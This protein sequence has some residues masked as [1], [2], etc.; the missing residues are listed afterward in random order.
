MAGLLGAGLAGR[1]LSDAVLGAA[2]T[3][4]SEEGFV[5][6]FDGKSLN[7]W[8]TNARPI[9]HGTGGKWRVEDWTITGEQDP[10]GSGNGGV[11]LSDREYGDFELALELAPDWGVDSGV[12]LRTNADGV[13]FQVYVDYHD[14][15][16]VG[17][18]STETVSGQRRMIIRPFNFFGKL[19]EQRKIKSLHTKPDERDVAWKQDYLRFSAT[20]ETWLSTWKIGAWNTLRIRCVGNY[21]QITTWINETK[22]AEFDGS[23]CPQPDYN[24]AEM[25]RQLGP[26]GPIGLQVHGG[27]QLW[28]RGAKCRWRN[29]RIKLL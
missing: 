11:L 18:I 27:K 14:H 1:H 22:M 6:I 8:H 19:D 2:T 25:L 15:G 4:P 3:N 23:S 24:K 26:K 12:F 20:P 28:T 17:W 29:I 10:P 21:P 5:P 13:C 7:G 9:I 16:N